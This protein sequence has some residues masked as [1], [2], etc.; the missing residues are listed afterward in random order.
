MNKIIRKL[1]SKKY[2]NLSVVLIFMMFP[3]LFTS[4]SNVILNDVEVW[5]SQKTNIIKNIKE[6]IYLNEFKISAPLEEEIKNLKKIFNKKEF[7]EKIKDVYFNIDKYY[8]DTKILKNRNFEEIR[9]IIIEKINE[10]NKI[11]YFKKNKQFEKDFLVLK[12]IKKQKLFLKNLEDFFKK[13]I[14]NFS[15]KSLKIKKG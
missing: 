6:E 2:L 7:I 9:K 3:P 5:K 15:M 10:F 12:T 4:A 11:D 13:H 8:T 1:I 14:D